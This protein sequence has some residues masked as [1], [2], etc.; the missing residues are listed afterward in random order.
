MNSS[1]RDI[2]IVEDDMGEGFKDPIEE[3]EKLFDRLR[4]EQWKLEE[5]L[6]KSGA[7]KKWP[8]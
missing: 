4:H 7:I 5:R 8:R 2:P 1:Q 3:K 6:H